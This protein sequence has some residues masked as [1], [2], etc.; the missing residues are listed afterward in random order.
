MS[1]FVFTSFFPARRQVAVRV[2]RSNRW[3]AWFADLFVGRKFVF[4]IKLNHATPSS[5]AEACGLSV[6]RFGCRRK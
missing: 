4:S 2:N 1:I 3:R 5:H 6:A